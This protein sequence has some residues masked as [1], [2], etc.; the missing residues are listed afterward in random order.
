MYSERL[1]KPRAGEYQHGRFVVPISALPTVTRVSPVPQGHISCF[2]A[3]VRNKITFET[4]HTIHTPIVQ[5]A[6][7]LKPQ[8]TQQQNTQHTTS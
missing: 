8:A 5:Q 6:T 3:Y 4:T 2:I 1:L 7:S